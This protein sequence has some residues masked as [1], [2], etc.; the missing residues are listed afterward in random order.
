MGLN[1]S[2]LGRSCEAEDENSAHI[3][4]KFDEVLVSLRHTYPGCLF[5]DSED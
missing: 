2:L 5:L 4:H 1:F 3:L